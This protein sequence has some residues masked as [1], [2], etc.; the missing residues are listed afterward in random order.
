MALKRARESD[1]SA[2]DEPE[3]KK[4]RLVVYV[5]TRMDYLDDYRNHGRDPAEV[6]VDVFHTQKE[7]DDHIRDEEDRFIRQHIRDHR[8][9]EKYAKYFV[10]DEDEDYDDL[11]EEAISCDRVALLYRATNGEYI[12]CTVRWDVHQSTIVSA[13]K[14]E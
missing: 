9:D 5:V 10:D 4:Q 2:E 12:P 8:R 1:A 3:T 13:P 11:D 14:I 7:A 6:T